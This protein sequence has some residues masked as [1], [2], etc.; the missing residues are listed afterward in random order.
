MKISVNVECGHE[1]LVLPVD[2]I[3]R[4]LDS[5]GLNLNQHMTRSLT[6]D[7]VRPQT[8]SQALILDTESIVELVIPRIMPFFTSLNH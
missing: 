4:V 7:L 1:Q 6:C 5:T 8:F 3:F 2:L